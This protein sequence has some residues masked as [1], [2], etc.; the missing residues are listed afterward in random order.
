MN[1]LTLMQVLVAWIAAS[2]PV[3]LFVGHCIFSVDH[4]E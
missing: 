2:V 4:Y 3:G 1:S